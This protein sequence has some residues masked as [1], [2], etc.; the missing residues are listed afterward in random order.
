MAP[1]LFETI[2]ASKIRLGVIIIQPVTADLYTDA[3][4]LRTL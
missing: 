2:N 3:L 1:Q 4:V